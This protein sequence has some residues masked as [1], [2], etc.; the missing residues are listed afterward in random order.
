MMSTIGQ[1]IAPEA[2]LENPRNCW[3]TRMGQHFK[4]IMKQTEK[5]RRASQRFGEK[6]TGWLVIMSWKLEQLNEEVGN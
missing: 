6:S 4:G 1:I 2:V 5:I 3:A